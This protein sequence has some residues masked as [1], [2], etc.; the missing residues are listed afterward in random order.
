MEPE[1][2]EVAL[3]GEPALSTSDSFTLLPPP[4]DVVKLRRPGSEV[5][6][7][8]RSPALREAALRASRAPAVEI[9]ARLSS[10]RTKLK[11]EADELRRERDEAL[12]TKTCLAER[13][14]EYDRA[15]EPLALAGGQALVAEL[16]AELAL[17]DLELETRESSHEELA[18][19]ALAQL[20]D[21]RR[22]IEARDQEIATLHKDLANA[23]EQLDALKAE[24]HAIWIQPVAT[25]EG[26]F[27]AE[28]PIVSAEAHAAEIEARDMVIAQLRLDRA[29]AA[30][31]LAAQAAEIHELRTSLALAGACT[32]EAEI[33][34]L[35]SA[36]DERATEVAGLAA[37]LEE[38][39]A[40][41]YHQPEIEALRAQIEEEVARRTQA[42]ADHSEEKDELHRLRRHA[43]EL[44]HAQVRAAALEADLA[45]ATAATAAL[46]AKAAESDALREKVVAL[47]RESVVRA[48]AALEAAEERKARAAR[49]LAIGF[50]TASV[51]DH[52]ATPPTRRARRFDD[53]EAHAR[54]YPTLDPKGK[55]ANARLE[56][57][58]RRFDRRLARMEKRREAELFARLE[59]LVRHPTP[60]DHPERDTAREERASRVESKGQGD[61]GE[62]KGPPA[63]TTRPVS[64]ML[65]GLIQANL[66][67]RANA[68]A[69][70]PKRGNSHE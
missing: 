60:S 69:E 30:A 20:R 41:C 31:Q 13:L 49:A 43:G 2:P 37:A 9:I 35:H 62:W 53:L 52:R 7:A 70:Q 47:E 6:P 4:A 45:A 44:E 59:K 17:R 39:S 46:Q 32:H 27:T 1:S 61:R 55:R 54:P 58:L 29:P 38:A 23:D 14:A 16:R 15:S 12:A 66:A 33:A 65:A 28:D 63:M 57:A 18:R 67:L 24:L 48:Q 10:E 36:L 56:K 26:D 64:G 68:G 21:E 25:Y 34:G 8:E 5:P 42:F 22:T 11:A 51:I 50:G 40:P 19:L 3:P